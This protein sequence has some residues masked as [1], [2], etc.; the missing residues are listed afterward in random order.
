M[1]PDFRSRVLARELV[2]GTFINLGSSI[3]AEITAGSGFDWLLIDI[4]HGSADL[5]SL[6]TQLQAIGGSSAVPL[7]RI[8]SNEPARFKRVLDM[9]AGGVMIPYVSTAEEAKQAVASMRYPPRGVRGVA[10]L[11]R[12]SGFGQ[13]FDD[14]FAN[15]HEQLVC[16]VQIETVEALDNIDEIAA[17]D[18]VDVLFIGPLDLS[19]NMGIPEQFTHERFLE[20]RAKVVEAAKNAGKAAGILLLNTDMIAD[21]LKAGFTCVAV[22]SDGGLVAAGMRQLAGAFSKH[23]K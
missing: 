4:E 9:G 13:N 2:A 19:V 1:S 17:V 16:V 22:G 7:V 8:A 11:N 6:M 23:R 3:T 5:E 14:Y 12:G 21:T 18:G 10:K 20:A 15:A